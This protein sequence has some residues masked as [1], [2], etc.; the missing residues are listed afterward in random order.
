MYLFLLLFT[1]LTLL[2]SLAE[3]VLPSLSNKL[4][5]L[6]IAPQLRKD[7]TAMLEGFSVLFSLKNQFLNQILIEPLTTVDDEK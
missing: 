2:S 4:S 1:S 7:C 5:K 3:V 6:E